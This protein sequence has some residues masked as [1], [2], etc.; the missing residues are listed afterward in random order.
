MKYLR[1]LFILAFIILISLCLSG[2]PKPEPGPLG[3]GSRR[4]DSR[5][6]PSEFACPLRFINHGDGTLT[7]PYTGLMWEQ[8]VSYYDKGLSRFESIRYTYAEAQERVELMAIGGHTDWRLPTM[9]EFDFLR[10]HTICNNFRANLPVDFSFPSGKC[11]T[12]TQLGF[13][14]S[15]RDKGLHNRPF[16][17]SD[18]DS[19]LWQEFIRGHAFVLAVRRAN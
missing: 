1:T 2:A 14:F 5:S 19:E 8:T 3:N 7:D 12:S 13:F 16:S 9:V 10:L 15:H 11:W 17:F 18:N 4:H 6:W